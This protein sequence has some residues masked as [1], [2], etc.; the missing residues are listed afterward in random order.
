MS[1]HSANKKEHR[2]LTL[3]DTVTTT[4]VGS[5][6]HLGSL[7]HRFSLVVTYATAAPTAATIQLQG[8]LDN[9]SWVDLGETTDVTTTTAGI[10][11]KDTPF[12]YIRGNL[13]AY[14]AGSCTGVSVLACATN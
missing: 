9:S 3:L 11:V 14:T 7:I 2:G 12:L 8:S 6:V 1:L 5:S 13:D 4:G 10:S